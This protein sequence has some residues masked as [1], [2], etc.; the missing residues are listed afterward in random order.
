MYHAGH[1]R[2]PCAVRSGPLRQSP[3]AASLAEVQKSH[4]PQVSGPRISAPAS[5]LLISRR[6]RQP[7]GPD[8][9]VAGRRGMDVAVRAVPEHRL[10]VEIVEAHAGGRGGAE[11]GHQVARRSRPRG[12]RGRPAPRCPPG[13][14]RRC[15]A[16]P[17]AGTAGPVRSQQRTPPHIVEFTLGL[18]RPLPLSAQPGTPGFQAHS[19][20]VC[21][22]YLATEKPGR[23]AADLRHLIDRHR[24]HHLG[25]GG[26]R[27]RR[28]KCRPRRR[29]PPLVDVEEEVVEG[30]VRGVEEPVVARRARCRRA[31]WR[32]RGRWRAAAPGV[33]R[34]VDAVDQRD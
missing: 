8:L 11:A 20:R 17:A 30:A 3:T 13:C 25:A 31:G 4:Q 16:A 14:C 29:C 27:G 7:L 19:V 33:P 6:R 22:P 2:P 23:R 32:C 12:R 34:P 21:G 1:G 24:H 15:S 10:V 18:Q 9:V 5:R 26:E 28:R